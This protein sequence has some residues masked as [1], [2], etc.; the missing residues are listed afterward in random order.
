MLILGIDPDLHTTG[1]AV[2]DTECKTIE[3]GV[4]HVSPKRRGD[5]AIVDM[6]EALE[7]LMDCMTMFGD[8]SIIE[9]PELYRG[10]KASPKS[11]LDLAMVA[12]IATG[13]CTAISKKTVL[14]TPKV[15][16]GSVKKEVK[17]ERILR[18]AGISYQVKGGTVIPEDVASVSPVKA[19]D[20][21]HC[22][23]AIGLAYWGWKRAE[24]GSPNF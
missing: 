17:H 24:S 9:K 13:H 6:S 2:L 7:D 8:I 1:V 14:V 4:A 23:D 15:W 19:K 3:V 21:T 11:I 16:K 5:N 22:I 10:G 20:W 12:G 18:E